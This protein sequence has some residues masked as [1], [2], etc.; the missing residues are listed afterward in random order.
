M[1]AKDQLKF[2]DSI[3]GMELDSLKKIKTLLLD[4]KMTNDN[5]DKLNMINVAIEK[6]N[7]L[8]RYF[9]KL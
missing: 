8:E 5:V 7:K 2:Y 6:N 9:E 1:K 3:E 4:K